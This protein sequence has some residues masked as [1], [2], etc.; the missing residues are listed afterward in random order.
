MLKKGKNDMFL[1]YSRVINPTS[2]QMEID[3]STWLK[4][5]NSKCLGSADNLYMRYRFK[6]QKHLSFGITME[7]DAG[8]TLLGSFFYDKLV[9]KIYAFIST[10]IFG[11][12]SAPSPIGGEGIKKIID[13][14]K[15]TNTTVE[16]IKEDILITGII[17]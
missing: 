15:V 17:E 3:D 11:G 2:G 8:E 14:I 9:N 10:T 6:Y 16:I 1:R 5:P 7:K 4:S 12:T 13:K